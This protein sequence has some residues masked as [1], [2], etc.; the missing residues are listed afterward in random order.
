MSHCRLAPPRA[1]RAAEVVRPVR[2]Q[3]V[4]VQP[5]EGL[6]VG[7]R[8]VFGGE[9]AEHCRLLERVIARLARVQRFYVEHMQVRLRWRCSC[10]LRSQN[11]HAC[12][13]VDELIIVDMKQVGQS[14]LTRLGHAAN[15][16]RRLSVH[17]CK[18]VAVGAGFKAY[19]HQLAPRLL[20]EERL[21][22]RRVFNLEEEAFNPDDV[23]IVGEPCLDVR[24]LLEHT[25]EAQAHGFGGHG[26]GAG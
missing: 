2:A 26:G 12:R 24:R 23:A 13:A 5:A 14:T 16:V 8:A 7:V 15:H 3:A 11:V 6:A 19:V 9:V 21:Q 10:K 17:L 20:R 4:G 22:L 1:V 18:V 25:H